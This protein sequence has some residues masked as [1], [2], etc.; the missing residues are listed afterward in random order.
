MDI[1]YY[2]ER[3]S[4]RPPSGA[5]C[6]AATDL[7]PL[8]DCRRE[9]LPLSERSQT[10]NLTRH[11]RPPGATARPVIAKEETSG[12]TGSAGGSAL[13]A[14][15]T[16]LSATRGRLRQRPVRADQWAR[17]RTARAT[18]SCVLQRWRVREKHRPGA[19]GGLYGRMATYARRGVDRRGARDGDRARGLA[20]GELQ[21]LARPVGRHLRRIR[22]S[23]RCDH[24]YPG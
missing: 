18:G 10:S 24:L 17:R 8:P 19:L 13:A 5:S 20:Q 15:R 16:G 14:R 4:I 7:R 12:S 2:T 22:L 6:A 21:S 1:G 11:A 3:G 23:G 9:A